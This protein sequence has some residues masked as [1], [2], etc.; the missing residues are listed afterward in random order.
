LKKRRSSKKQPYGQEKGNSSVPFTVRFILYYGLTYLP[1][2]FASRISI[3][4]RSFCLQDIRY[5]RGIVV[6]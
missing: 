1:L 3:L 5:G 6:S 2:L 4:P